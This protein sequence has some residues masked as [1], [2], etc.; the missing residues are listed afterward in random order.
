MGVMR[1]YQERVNAAK[2]EAAAILA[3]AD[4]TAESIRKIGVC[5]RVCV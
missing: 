4:A 2:A 5:V 3:V 1:H